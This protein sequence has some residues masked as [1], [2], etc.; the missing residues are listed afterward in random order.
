M[1][2]LIRFLKRLVAL[3]LVCVC[4]FAFFFIRDGYHLYKEALAETPVELVM[5]QIEKQPNYTELSQ[6]PQIYQDAVI[7][8][9]DHRFYTHHGIDYIAVVRALVHN[10]QS[11]SIVEGGST[12]TQQLAKNQFFTQKK[13][14]D[15]KIAEVFMVREI[16][17][18]YS[19][20]KILELY[21]NSIYYGEGFYNL[22]DASMGYFGKI[23]SDLSD[24]ECTMLAG[25]PNAPSVYAITTNPDLAKQ[26]QKQV[27]NDMVTWGYLTREEADSIYN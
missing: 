9:E 2:T 10:L 4:V 20:E 23:P 24:G 15:R 16:E 27:L 7:A 19:K 8:T 25:L 22:Y 1:R 21:I 11:G 17:K 14:L 3:A 26:R 6:I 13:E 5:E 18:R 12:I